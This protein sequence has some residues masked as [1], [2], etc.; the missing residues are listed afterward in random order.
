MST[1]TTQPP[2]ISV[3][4]LGLDFSWTAAHRS[5]LIDPAT[6]RATVQRRIAALADVR[7]LHTETL[8]VNPDDGTARAVEVVG[9]RLREGPGGG[10]NDVAEGGGGGGGKKKSW[11]GVI[12]GWGMRGV[13]DT[14]ELFEGVVN[15][16]REGA[17]G[18]RM[19]F[20]LA[21]ANHLEV[22]RRNFGGLVEE[23]GV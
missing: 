23:K 20:T 4:I 3:L 9:E 14:S 19:M 22:L 11:D 18:A 21:E 6:L 7:D 12:F 5:A 16:V 13:A 10:E 15:C 1:T 8:L 17:P 2:K